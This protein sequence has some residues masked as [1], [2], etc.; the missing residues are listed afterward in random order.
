MPD[1]TFSLPKPPDIQSGQDI[2]DSIMKHIEPEL[3]SAILPTLEA[4]YKDEKPKE[5]EKRKK[6]YNDAFAKFYEQYETYMADLHAR[7]HSYHTKAMGN[8]ED[9]SRGK[10]AHKL[11]DIEAAIF[12]LS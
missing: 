3:K 7:I 9:Y 1:Q 12:K 11:E 4:K 5:Q 8:I 6:R 10:E 2:Y